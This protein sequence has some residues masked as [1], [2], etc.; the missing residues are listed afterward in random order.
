MKIHGYVKM[1]FGFNTATLLPQYPRVSASNF[2]VNLTYF[3]FLF[4]HSLQQQLPLAHSSHSQPQHGHLP[5]S[6]LSIFITPY[7]Y[8]HVNIVVK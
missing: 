3:F 8:R 1:E 7:S 6:F 4:L 2:G 5:F